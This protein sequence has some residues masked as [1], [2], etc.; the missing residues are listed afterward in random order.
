MRQPESWESMFM[1]MAHVIARRSKDNS[2]QAGAVLVAADGRTVLGLAYNGPSPFIDDNFDWSDR[3]LKRS[4]VNHA[5]SNCLWF[6]VAAHGRE[7]LMAGLLF[8][9]GKPCSQ[10]AKEIA[11]AGLSTVVWD[12]TNPAQPKMVDEG[13]WAKTTDILKRAD[14]DLVPYSFYRSA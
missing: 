1:A 14:V 9:N 4:L 12:D 8:V 7:A 13:E 2:F 10:C 5:E 11:R 6:A 3:S